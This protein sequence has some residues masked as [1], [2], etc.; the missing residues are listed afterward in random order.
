MRYYGS[1]EQIQLEYY[2]VIK[3]ALKSELGPYKPNRIGHLTLCN[4]F[5]CRFNPKKEVAEDVKKSIIDI[6]DYMARYNYSLDVNT[7]GLYKEYCG[8]I[9]P[10]PWIVD[11]A[12]KLGIQLVY[13]SDSHAV[14]DVGRAYKVF[15]KIIT[16]TH[17]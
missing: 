10:S 7:A 4:K 13:G 11:N 1:Y 9:Y 2:R 8:E 12:Y 3:E 15:E 17:L 14:A 6:L 16:Q 5:Q